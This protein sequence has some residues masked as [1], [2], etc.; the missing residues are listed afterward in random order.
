MPREHSAQ[1][2]AKTIMHYALYDIKQKEEND[3]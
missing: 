1:K 3:L 2:M